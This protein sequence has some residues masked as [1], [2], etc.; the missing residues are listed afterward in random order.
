M[1]AK[2]SKALLEISDTDMAARKKGRRNRSPT[3]LSTS[4]PA[5]R[6]FAWRYPLIV[7]AIAAPLL[8]IY[9]YPYAEDGVMAKGIHSYLTVY[10]KIVGAAVS[11]FEP[12]V[13]VTGDLVAGPSNSIQIVKTCDAMEVNILLTAALAGLPVSLRRRLVAVVLSVILLVLVNVLRICFLYWLGAHIPTWFHQA[14][15]T[16]APLCLIVF[17][18]VIF[19]IAI[20]K[21]AP[22]FPEGEFRKQ[23]PS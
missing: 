11:V 7:A 4:D 16:L 19:L 13:L 14:H 21:M 8:A 23:V 12:H 9:F 17:A 5:S 10:A 18:T 15:Q 3:G 2:P 22:R 20:S 1:N 6:F